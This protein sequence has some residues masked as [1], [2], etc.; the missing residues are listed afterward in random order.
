MK[1]CAFRKSNHVC[2]HFIHRRLHKCNWPLT[3][4][5]TF[6]IVV[7]RISNVRFDCRKTCKILV[8]SDF[9]NCNSTVYRQQ[10]SFSSGVSTSFVEI[11]FNFNR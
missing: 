2:V 4:Q 10:M 9:K 11:D 6:D 8:T 1:I 7:I 5:F 3:E